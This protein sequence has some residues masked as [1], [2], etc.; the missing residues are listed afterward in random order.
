[1]DLKRKQKVLLKKARDLAKSHQTA[2]DYYPSD[3]T[4]SF[5][6][7]FLKNNGQFGT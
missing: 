4:F 2:S 5:Q 6:H 1:M 3:S 7:D